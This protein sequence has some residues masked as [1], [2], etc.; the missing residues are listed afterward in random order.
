MSSLALTSFLLPLDCQSAALSAVL[1][2]RLSSVL[3]F[4]GAA[5]ENCSEK[6]GRGCGITP[7]AVKWGR[8]ASCSSDPFSFSLRFQ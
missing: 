1:S 7:E 2:P 4:Y 6:V 5:A 8:G 3:S